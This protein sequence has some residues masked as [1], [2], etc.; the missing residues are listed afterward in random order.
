MNIDPDRIKKV[1]KDRDRWLMFGGTTERQPH[2]KG[3]TSISWSDPDD[4]HSFEEAYSAMQEREEWGIGYVFQPGDDEYMLDL[5][6]CFDDDGNPREWFRGLDRFIDAGAYMEWSVS[7]NGIHIPIEGEP[8]EWW[9]DCEV[10]PDLHQGVDVLTNKFCA[11]TTDELEQSGGEVTDVNAAPFLFHSYKNIKGESPRLDT[12]ASKNEYTGELDRETVEDALGELDPDMAHTEWVKVGYAVHAWD[13]GST[14]Q[15]VFE[16]WSQ[17]GGKWDRDAERTVEWIWGEADDNGDI[18]VGTLIYK[19]K[20]EGWKPPRPTPQETGE[21]QSSGGT[22]S[23]DAGGNDDWAYVR[24]LFEQGDDGSARLSAANTLEA[25]THWMYVEESD[26]LWVY[27]ESRGY[28]QPRGEAY[29]NN[30]LERELMDYYKGHQADEIIRRL[31]HRN[32]TRRKELNARTTDKKLVC[33]GN[34]VVNLENGKLLDHSPEYKFTRGL[35]WDYEPAKADAKP[36]MDLLDDVTKREQ[37]RDT[38]LDHLAHGLMPG[39]PYRAFVMMYGPGSNGK[40]VVGDVFRQFVGTENTASVE[41]QDFADDDFATGALPSAFINVGDDVSIGELRDTSTLKSLTGGGTQRANEKF[42]KKFDFKN[43]AA[44][45]FSAN[46]PPRFAEKSRAVADR[47]YP[48]HMPYRFVEDPDTDDPAQFKKDPNIVEKITGNDAAMRGLLLKVVEHAQGVIERGGQYSMQETP[49]ERRER[50][51]SHSDPIKRFALTYLEESDSGTYVLKDDAYT[52]Y[53]RMCDEQ[54]ERKTSAD[55]FKRKVSELASLNAESAR[56]RSVT[57]GDGRD[58]AWKYVTFDEQATRLLGDRLTERY[59]GESETATDNSEQQEPERD[60][61]AHGAM[62]VQDVALDPTG[63]ADVTVEVLK[64]EHPGGDNQPA[65]RA[66]VKDDSSAID[67][68]SW[69]NPDALAKGNTVLIENAEVDEWDGTSQLVIDDAVT[70]VTPVQKGVGHTEPENTDSGQESLHAA[71]DGGTATQQVRR[72][73]T[74]ECNSGETLK[75]AQVAG[76]TGIDPES[77]Q[78]ALETIKEEDSLLEAGGDGFEVL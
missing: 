64:V 71:T 32:Q 49:R 47:L 1:F 2:W 27:D 61:D 22:D 44:M 29:A 14:G 38:L 65:M 12:P 73:I 40:T 74:T 17:S 33:V 76:D 10:G 48:I 43:Q 54:N 21:K 50:Y 18:G 15:S 55:S 36:V 19:A 13:S 51:E 56:P 6:G 53:T 37:D 69:D 66:T 26:I 35:E 31:R 52:A 72:Y 11:F 45:F 62:P 28:F 25:D 68:I 63:Y 59:F 34:G 20:Q 16:S 57:P 7:G 46:E 41:L 58:R 24:S 78:S 9:R 60:D 75:T 30:L 67:V 42:E 77:V 5:D 39:H 70:S 4:W 8:P 23:S 3:D